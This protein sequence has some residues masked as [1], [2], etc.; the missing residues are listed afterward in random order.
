MEQ[1]LKVTLECGMGGVGEPQL[2]NHPLSVGGYQSGTDIS[3]VPQL[4]PTSIPAPQ[5]H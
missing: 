2:Q 4:M 3:T 1:K 5:E